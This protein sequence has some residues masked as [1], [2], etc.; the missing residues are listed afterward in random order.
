MLGPPIS[1]V[2][3]SSR[4]TSLLFQRHAELQEALKQLRKLCHLEFCRVSKI[5]ESS[6]Y[7][8]FE[9]KLASGNISFP[10]ELGGDDDMPSEKIASGEIPG[11]QP[12][13]QTA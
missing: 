4:E 12:T 3:R 6:P 5:G 11:L 9:A 10:P 13:D 8:A 7:E 1:L 2:R